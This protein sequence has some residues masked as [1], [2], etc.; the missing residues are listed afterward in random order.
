MSWGIAAGSIAASYQSSIGYVVAIS[1]FASLQ[2]L[3]MSVVLIALGAA[4]GT[5]S[6]PAGAVALAELPTEPEPPKSFGD[7]EGHAQEEVQ[8]S[9][10]SKATN[11]FILLSF[12]SLDDFGSGK[13]K[14]IMKV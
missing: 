8:D 14:S 3:G 10:T 4:A 6:L 1:A 9:A 12:G 5:V 7:D 2:S 13:G 11:S